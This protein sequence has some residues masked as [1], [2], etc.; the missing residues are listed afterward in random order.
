MRNISLKKNLK[1]WKQFN[2]IKNI[3]KKEKY[4]IFIE[5]V[6]TEQLMC[7]KQAFKPGDKCTITLKMHGTSS[8][9]MYSI[10]HERFKNFIE[11]LL[12][13]T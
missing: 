1:R 4:P 8:R 9:E 11:K 2:K 12:K 13:R 5:H 6:D 7:N 3:S 10:K